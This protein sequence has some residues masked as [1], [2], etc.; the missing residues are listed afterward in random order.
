MKTLNEET[1]NAIVSEF[2]TQLKAGN[3]EQSLILLAHDGNNG[4]CRIVG[5]KKMLVRSFLSV[6]AA[7]PEFASVVCLATSV[8]I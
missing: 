1:L 6:M 7:H 4:D 2:M 3:N 5:T 8:Y